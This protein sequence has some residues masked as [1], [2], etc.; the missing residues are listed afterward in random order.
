MNNFGNGK[1]NGKINANELIKKASEVNA[2]GDASEKDVNDFINK[3]LSESQ[4]KAVRELLSDEEKTKALLNSD[5][6]K[7]IFKKFFGGNGNG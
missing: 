6:A 2:H 5:A 7:T 3:N 1:I 4:A